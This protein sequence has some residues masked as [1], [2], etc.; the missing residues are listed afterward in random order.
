VVETIT[1]IAKDVMK[2]SRISCSINLVTAD[3]ENVWAISLLPRLPGSILEIF[4]QKQ[5]VVQFFGGP[6]V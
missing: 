2:I 5:I 4:V 3:I 1:Q 6:E